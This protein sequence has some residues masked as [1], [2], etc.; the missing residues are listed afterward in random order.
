LAEVIWSSG[1]K[2]LAL[3]SRLIDGQSP[4]ATV[5][6]AVAAGAGVGSDELGA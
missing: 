3:R 2:R 4:G 6:G 1:E 5:T